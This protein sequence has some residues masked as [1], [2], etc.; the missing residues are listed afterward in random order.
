[1]KRNWKTGSRS[2][3]A[4]DYNQLETKNLLAAV[5]LSGTAGDDIL[6]IEYTNKGNSVNVT[7]NGQLTEGLDITDGLIIDLGEGNDVTTIENS[8]GMLNEGTRVEL[9]NTEEVCATTGGNLWRVFASGENGET[10]RGSFNDSIY[11]FDATLLQGGN[12]VDRFNIHSFIN[13]IIQGGDG[14]DIFS[15]GAGPIGTS[16]A[17]VN[18]QSGNDYFGVQGSSISKVN[19]DDGYDRLSFRP[20]D[21]DSIDITL[22]I[23]EDNIW[24]FNEASINL[25]R[26]SGDDEKSNSLNYQTELD[27]DQLAKVNIDYIVDGELTYAMMPDG[28]YMTFSGFNHLN[29][30]FILNDR[31][32]VRAT[33]NDLFIYGAKVVQLSSEFDIAD[34]N[35]DGIQH[36]VSVNRIFSQSM[37]RSIQLPQSPPTRAIISNQT[38]IGSTFEV[39][40]NSLTGWSGGGQLQFGNDISILGD[41]H[42]TFVAFSLPTILDIHG[43]DQGDDSF[44]ITDPIANTS[45]SVTIHGYGGN[46]TATFGSSGDLTLLENSATAFSF[47]GGDGND[48][49][50]LE[51]SASNAQL[52]RNFN[53]TYQVRDQTIAAFFED[54][55]LD[56]YN[57]LEVSFDE[58]T[59]I[60]RID[61]TNNYQ[62]RFFVAPSSTKVAIFSPANNEE[63]DELFVESTMGEL[64]QGDED[65]GVWLFDNFEPIFFYNVENTV[66]IEDV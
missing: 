28:S 15:F 49:L 24:N 20:S 58:S 45:L 63:I 10:I 38:G 34:G 48:R 23:A 46:D 16:T 1:M 7:L 22:E 6:S 56:Q 9:H 41:G 39:G 19:G 30:N 26:I 40:P 54:E 52:D 33:T 35:L 51:D 14:N 27:A 17:T 3:R 5:T 57:R 37:T 31:V 12:G 66:A 36:N 8:M 62:N 18:G 29:L 25:E 43:S 53:R 55:P 11:F 44:M 42:P 59:E 60:A 61:A 4:H 50:V 2:K 65:D 21:L 47:I 32:Y 13:G 64:L